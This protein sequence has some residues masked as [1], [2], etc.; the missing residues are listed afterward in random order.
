MEAV[1]YPPPH[2]FTADWL[3]ETLMAYEGEITLATAVIFAEQPEDVTISATLR[4]QACTTEECFIPQ[5]LTF[6][7]ADALSRVPQLQERWVRY[8][9]VS[10]RC[11]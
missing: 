11:E 10:L 7:A 1:T 2:P 3:D 9:W 8:M 4:F 5:Q 6:S